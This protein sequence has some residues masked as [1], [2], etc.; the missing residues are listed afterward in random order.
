MN[1]PSGELLDDREPGSEDLVGFK[2]ALLAQHKKR[3]LALKRSVDEDLADIITARRIEVE[4]IVHSLRRSHEKHLEEVLKTNLHH[5]KRQKKSYEAEL[6][7]IF[8]ETLE[9]AVRSRLETFR[10]SPRY[11][12][13]LE[14]LAVEAQTCIQ[15]NST[16]SWVALVEEGDALFL[17]PSSRGN[18]REVREELW[19]VWGGLV[20]VEAGGGGRV[21]DNTFRA[22]W[23]RLPSLFA[24]KPDLRDDL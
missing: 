9:K 16:L 5:V 8:F 17:P 12:A 11:G 21:V 14:A 23:K 4:R 10:H 3:C 24:F 7:D 13:V 2:E 15:G 18:I 1:R 22:R 6:Q 20:L 19:D